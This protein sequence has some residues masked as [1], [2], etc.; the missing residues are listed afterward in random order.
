MFGS[1]MSPASNLSN[2]FVDASCTSTTLRD[3]GVLLHLG[4]VCSPYM[5][6]LL[7][8]ENASSFCMFEGILFSSI[9]P[10][11]WYESLVRAS[12]WLSCMGEIVIEIHGIQ[13]FH[14]FGGM[15]C[16]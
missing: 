5:E 8:P 7:P 3:S 2:F 10:R 15:F 9:V 6:K 11:T 12:S 4:R 13:F 1:I 16:C 14:V